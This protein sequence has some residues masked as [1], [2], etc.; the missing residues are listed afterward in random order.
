[1]NFN[2]DPT[3]IDYS[4][5]AEAFFKSCGLLLVGNLAPLQISIYDMHI[6]A[7]FTEFFRILAYAGAS[8]AFFKFIIN[9][10]KGTEKKYE[11]KDKEND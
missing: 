4:R 8:V 10:F 2:F 5:P 6:P 1:M 9:L 7:I 3:N 11:D